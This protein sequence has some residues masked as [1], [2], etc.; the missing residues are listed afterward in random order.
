M[1]VS[2][3]V[4]ADVIKACVLNIAVAMEMRSSDSVDTE[5]ENLKRIKKL[6]SKKQITTSY[7]KKLINDVAS[8]TQLL[9]GEK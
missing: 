9:A 5:C 1:V 2:V 4:C 3:R 6:Y 7:V 8:L